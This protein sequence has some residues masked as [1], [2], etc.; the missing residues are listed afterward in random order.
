M[1]QPCLFMS[2]CEN[3]CLPDWLTEKLVTKPMKLS[4]LP[5]LSFVTQHVAS[6]L[7]ADFGMAILAMLNI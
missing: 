4:L 3:A 7:V 5:L 6:I 2:Q 1:G